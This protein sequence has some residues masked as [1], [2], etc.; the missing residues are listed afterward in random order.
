MKIELPYGRGKLPV[1]FPDGLQVTTIR[2]GNP[3][4]QEQL[5]MVRAVGEI[6]ALNVVIDDE[7]RI[8]F[9]NFG[10]IEPS[11]LEAV[12]FMRTYKVQL[13]ATGLRPSDRADIY[14]EPVPSVEKAVQESAKA[15]GDN[16]VAVVPEGPYVIPVYRP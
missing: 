3:L 11:H 5:N 1:T 16:H 8:G 7:R 12:A 15:H 14:V 9:V 2:E 10:P 6:L 13:Y 4:H